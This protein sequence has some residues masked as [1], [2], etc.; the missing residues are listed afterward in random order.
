MY[1]LT[2]FFLSI[3]YEQ[4]NGVYHQDSKHYPTWMH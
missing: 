2:Q 3:T 1:A 4:A